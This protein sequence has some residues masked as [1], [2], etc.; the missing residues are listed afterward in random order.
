MPFSFQ[1]SMY[2]LDGLYW[3]TLMFCASRL[4]HRSPARVGMPSGG[5]PG[6]TITDSIPLRCHAV[7]W[8]ECVR[9][10]ACVCVCVCVCV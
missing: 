1:S 5:Q 3:V 7:T 9:A 10:C 4:H 8:K 2:E 6:T